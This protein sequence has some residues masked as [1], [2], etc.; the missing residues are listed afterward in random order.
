MQLAARASGTLSRL[1]AIVVAVAAS[2][3]SDA[4][5]CGYHLQGVQVERVALNIVYPEAMHVLGAVSGAQ[6][7]KRLPIAAAPDLFGYQRTVKALE[8]L[9]KRLVPGGPQLSFSLVLIEPM[10][11]T[12]F[13]VGD[14]VEMQVHVSAPEPGELV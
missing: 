8:R 1:G 3:P 12:R 2:L 6:I 4:A 10:L 11:W 14:S 9:A 13:D 7:E 5:A